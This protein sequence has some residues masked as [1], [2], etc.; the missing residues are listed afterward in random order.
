M[1]DNKTSAKRAE[2]KLPLSGIRVV[3]LTRLL[4]GPWASQMLADFGADVLKLEQPGT[5]DPS[6]HNHP[7]FRHDS[8]YYNIVNGSKRSLAVDL[9]QPAGR[10]VVH[11][12][13]ETADVVLESFRPG[14]ARKLAVD[15]ATLSGINPRIVYCSISGFGQSGA[16]SHIAGHDLVLQA[17]TGLL[18]QSSE[19]SPKE[20]VPS[21]QAADYAGSLMAIIG[22]FA[23]LA[24]REK[25]GVG[26]EIDLSMFDALFS[27]CG[28]TLTSA[29]AR[30]AGF[31]GEPRQ[32]VF[33]TNPRYATYATKDN[34]AVAVSLLEAKAWKEFSALVNRPELVSGSE[35]LADRLTSHGERGALYAQ[36]LIEYC[37]A[38]TRDEIVREM[39]AAG[40]AVCPVYTPDEAAQSDVVKSRQMIDFVEH[41][42]EGRIPYLSNPLA[43]SGLCETRRPAPALGEHSEDILLELGYSQSEIEALV[44]TKAVA[45]GAQ[46]G[47]ESS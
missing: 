5:G 47:D 36:A 23:A 39:D 7:R 37:A 27:M 40:I 34:K 31:S 10:A 38:R 22:V 6:R 33:G 21:F 9:S 45:L 20:A 30:L 15:Y 43:A 11:R 4:P 24:K 19:S 2:G 1:S 14:V 3:D 29:L 46:R 12:L 44:T 13:I 41:P 26:S 35:T 32:E 28:I 16:L 17:V 18:A 8:V 42:R 25:T